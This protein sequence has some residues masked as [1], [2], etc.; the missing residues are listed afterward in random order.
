M[1]STT[2]IAL[3]FP[4]ASSSTSTSEGSWR[5]RARVE[6]TAGVGRP[7]ASSPAGAYRRIAP[8]YVSATSTEPSGSA[9]TPSGCWS[10]AWAASPSTKPKS[11]RPVPT[12]VPTVR[13][14][15][16]SR[17]QRIAEVSESAAHRVA[18]GP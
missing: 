12:A 16:A 7:A 15:S 2:T 8:L 4:S 9:V 5:P 6:T 18:S 17:T 14:P 1:V 11:N 13:S 10:R 3:A